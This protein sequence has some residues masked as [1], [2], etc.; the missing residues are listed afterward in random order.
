MK[1]L[2]CM[3]DTVIFNRIVEHEEP[4][5]RFEG[6]VNV[7]ATHIQQDEIDKAKEK[8]PAKH[9]RLCR[10]FKELVL[11]D[12]GAGGVGLVPTESAV[13]NVSKWDHAKWSAGDPLCRRIKEELDERNHRENNIQDALIAETA[14][15]NRLILV[16]ADQD[17]KD[18]AEG[19]GA[20]CMRWDEL[21]Q[22]CPGTATKA[23]AGWRPC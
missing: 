15:K 21:L 20:K 9:S 23:A 4:V 13:W 6:R 16:T 19:L 1:R 14:I 11:G 3:F 12:P 8:Y 10:V 17:L 7:F 2:K 18:V 5:D 22:Y